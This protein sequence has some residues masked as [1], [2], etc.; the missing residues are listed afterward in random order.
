MNV[1][2]AQQKRLAIIHAENIRIR[3]ELKKLIEEGVPLNEWL[4][5]NPPKGFWKLMWRWI[6]LRLWIGPQLDKLYAKR[7]ELSNRQDAVIES[8]DII[9]SGQEP[10][11]H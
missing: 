11:L 5:K 8:L 3:E 9:Q 1:Q 2:E 10:T 7:E 4:D 6:K